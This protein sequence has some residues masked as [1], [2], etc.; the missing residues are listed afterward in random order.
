MYKGKC[1]RLFGNRNV[2]WLEAEKCCTEQQAHLLSVDGEHFFSF[3]IPF[4]RKFSLDTVDNVTFV[5]IIRVFFCFFL[6]E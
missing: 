3:W 5:S 4:A 2:T 1:V 6:I